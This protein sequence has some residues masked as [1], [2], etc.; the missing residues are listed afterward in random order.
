MATRL[1]GSEP[2]GRAGGLGG[3]EG[4]GGGGAPPPPL[5]S[6]PPTPP[7]ARRAR[8]GA[9]SAWLN[10]GVLAHRGRL[11]RAV[12]GPPRFLGVY[13]ASGTAGGGG[14]EAGGV[15]ARVPPAASAAAGPAPCSPAPAPTGSVSSGE[16]GAGKREVARGVSG[17]PG[18]PPRFAVGRG[19]PP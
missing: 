8:Q 5:P 14:G 17:W 18:P 15:C 13:R 3:G 4:G 9:P 12:R 16:E 10:G 19:A 1:A 6:P 2:R 7:R 11:S